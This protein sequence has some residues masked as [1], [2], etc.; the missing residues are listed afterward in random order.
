MMQMQAKTKGL[1]LVLEADEISKG[2]S[3]NFKPSP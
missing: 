2:G 3:F 1:K